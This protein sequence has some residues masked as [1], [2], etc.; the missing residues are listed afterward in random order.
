M[1]GT[2]FEEELSARLRALASTAPT[3]PS[4]RSIPTPVESTASSSRWRVLAAAVLLVVVGA[5]TLWQLDRIGREPDIISS[6]SVTTIPATTVQT[7]PSSST[8]DATL[9]R[10][11]DTGSGWRSLPAGPAD[12]RIFPVS[13]WTGTEIIVWGGETESE[14]VWA[15]DGAAFNVET[16]VWRPLADS[17]L[18]ARSEHVAVWTGTEVLICCGR[19]PSGGEESAAAY[20]PVADSWRD[21]TPPPFEADFAVAV[22]TGSELLVTGG[23]NFAGAAAYDPEADAWTALASPPATIERLA[24]VAWTGEELIVWPRLFTDAPGLIYNRAFDTWRDLPPLPIDLAVSGGSMIWTGTEIIVWGATVRYEGKSVGARIGLNDERWRPIAQ[25]PLEAFDRW[26]GVDGSSSAAWTG[27]EM[28]IFAG[29]IGAETGVA[30]PPTLAYDPEADTWRRFDDAPQDWYDPQMLWTGDLAVVLTDPL[31][32]IAPSADGQTL[33]DGVAAGVSVEDLPTPIDLRV[34]SVRPNNP[35]LA[36]TD[37]ATRSVEVYPPGS[38]SIGSGGVSG[39]AI[40]PAGDI[41]VWGDAV[42]VFRNG[43]FKAA[44]IELR[45]SRTAVVSG[46]ATELFVQPSADGEELWI[47][48]PAC[49]GVPSGSTIIDR[50]DIGTGQILTFLEL[51]EQAFPVGEV[52]DGLILNVTGELFDTGDGFVPILTDATVALVTTGGEVSQ[53]DKGQAVATWNSFVVL[54]RPNSNDLVIRD[55]RD[56]SEVLVPGSAGWR[57]SSVGG[58]SIPSTAQPLPTVSINGQLL[59]SLEGPEFGLNGI[60]TSSSIYILDLQTGATSVLEHFDGGS[61]LATWSRDGEWVL[62]IQDGDF[63]LQN[64]TTDQTI[65][66]TDPIPEEHF[67]LGAG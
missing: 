23:S 1:N 13:V 52:D 18:T 41:A 62:T 30:R 19:A 54:Q 33:V 37:L 57:W 12:G 16:G 65:H 60:P 24:D 38:T 28:L 3:E 6:V 61:P 27:I 59:I 2:D 40:T 8:P 9:A 63:K 34:L 14:A 55:L 10:A 67:V 36:V 50:V 17:P 22:W 4:P 45:P 48:Q 43:E 51:A 5:L 32:A 35:S 46:V 64:P 15:N 53:L 20:D 25:D 49:C 26:N 11:G 47:V 58:P 56:A 66:V 29:A 21:L 31:L 42:Y 39:A 7:P 44:P